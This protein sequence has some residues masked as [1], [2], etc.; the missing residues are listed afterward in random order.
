VR[1]AEAGGVSV[2]DETGTTGLDVLRELQG[3]TQE[4]RAGRGEE[5][6]LPDADHYRR[7]AETFVAGGGARLIVG[8]RGGAAVSAVLCGLNGARAYYYMGGTNAAGLEV[9]A[10]TL[11][12]TRAATLLATS[13]ARV[14]NLGGVARAAEAADHPAH[15]LYRFKEGFGATRVECASST[16]TT[17]AKSAGTT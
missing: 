3:A 13:G 5:M 7:L 12:L 6:E 15:G 8:R 14:L 10:A 4:R 11:V 1:D 9:N 16:W 17:G 2:A